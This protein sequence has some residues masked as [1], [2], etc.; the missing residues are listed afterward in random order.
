M[1]CPQGP[2]S[3]HQLT[4]GKAPS[5]REVWEEIPPPLLEQ[6][7]CSQIYPSH[8]WLLLLIFVLQFARRGQVLCLPQQFSSLAKGDVFVTIR[9][10]MWTAGLQC[11]KPTH[12]QTPSPSSQ[13]RLR[14]CGRMN[15]NWSDLSGSVLGLS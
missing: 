7:Q 2:S 9:E 10:V 14:F 1:S 13:K 6:S 11:Y 4:H 5:C 15:W 3:H 8:N 12:Q